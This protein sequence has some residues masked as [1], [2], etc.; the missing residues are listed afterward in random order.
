MLL[1]S[2]LSYLILD[3]LFSL[4]EMSI[5][6]VISCQPLIV[7]LF[8]SVQ[9]HDAKHSTAYLGYYNISLRLMIN[10][11]LQCS[12]LMKIRLH[13]RMDTQLRPSLAA[14]IYLLGFQVG[15][16]SPIRQ[17]HPNRT[18]TTHHTNHTLSVVCVGKLN[19]AGSM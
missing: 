3:S 13:K 10:T 1:L 14:L 2:F 11:L 5:G 17:A 6:C 4:C 9:Y 18:T 15:P 8:S 19:H 7:L 12:K 16:T